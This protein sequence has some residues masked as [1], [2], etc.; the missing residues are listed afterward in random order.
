MQATTSGLDEFESVRSHGSAKPATGSWALTGSTDF[1]ITTVNVPD[2][3]DVQ[4]VRARADADDDRGW[5]W[6]AR[7]NTLRTWFFRI[8]MAALV[9]A[10]ALFAWDAAAPLRDELTAERIASRLS[11][12]LNVPVQV[13]GTH[14]EWQPSPRY[15]VSGI[16]LGDGLRIERVALH[17][18]WQ[19]AWRALRGGGWVWGEAAV[20]PLKLDVARARR[21]LHLIP[22]LNHALPATISTLRLPSVELTDATLLPGRYELV[23]RRDGADG[24]RVLT[25]LDAGGATMTLKVRAL[26]PGADSP[27][28]FE[29]E[30]GN[31]RLP[32]GLGAPW[33]EVRASGVA[34]ADLI[35]VSSFVLVGY[36]GSVKGEVYAAH[37]RD[38]MVTGYA[39]AASLDI[40]SMLRYLRGAKSSDG[41]QPAPVPMSGAATLELQLAG[42]GATLA[43][44]TQ[45]TLAA[46]TFQ[47]RWGTLNGINLG[48]AA[49]R[50]GGGLSGGTTRF[51]TLEGGLSIG[52]AGVVLRDLRG[53]SG[54]MKTYG[55]VAVA[56]DLGLSGALRVDLGAT[57]VQA[58][59]NL[60][61]K[62]T[63]LAP[64]FGR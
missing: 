34:R 60:K 37:G 43:D 63:V 9:V 45:A 22:N 62:G 41:L 11:T 21:L 44:A 15:V 36:Y 58:P 26:E 8:A 38:W 16:D 19:D 5:V 18:N 51:T 64:Q 10:G 50:P 27:I 6:R 12:A 25:L 61:V 49:T 55:Q 48:Y 13:T 59:L 40:E 31:W 3:L 24:T 1:A 33:N 2:R 54:A 32:V 4:E 29:L 42:R 7:L 53:K 46:G 52:R 17:F 20:A 30:A 56:P 14:F 57:R 23:V 28:G 47:V 39:Q 35:E